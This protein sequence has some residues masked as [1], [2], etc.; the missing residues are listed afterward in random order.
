MCVCA[1]W[2]GGEDK[3]GLGEGKLCR[4]LSATSQMQLKAPIISGLDFAYFAGLF[5]S[6]SV[7][8]SPDFSQPWIYSVTS[9]QKWLLL[10]AVIV[11]AR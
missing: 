10:L 8:C 1:W 6:G 3:E 2:G 4:D 9:M 7:L 5:E 11:C